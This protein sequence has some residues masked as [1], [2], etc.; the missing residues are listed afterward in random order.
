MSSIIE[1]GPVSVTGK[2][3]LPVPLKP[4]GSRARF[5]DGR[6][7]DQGCAGHVTQRAPSLG[8]LTVLNVSELEAP[9]ASFLLTL[10]NKALRVECVGDGATF[11]FKWASAYTDGKSTKIQG[12]LE[13]Q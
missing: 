3:E 2:T 12:V 7:L 11:R 1:S 8:G 5:F 6:H 13:K 9:L 4:P 10:D